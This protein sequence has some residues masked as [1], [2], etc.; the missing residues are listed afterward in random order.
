[1]APPIVYASQAL[2]RQFTGTKAVAANVIVSATAT[3]RHNNMNGGSGALGTI[4]PPG[5]STGACPAHHNRGHLIGNAIGGPGGDAQNLVTLVSGTN[6]P[7][8]YEYED[9]LKRFVLLQTSHAREPF[10]YKVECDYAANAY[11]L[12]PGFPVPGAT[13]NPFCLFPA[14]ARL[15]LSV[16]DAA[17]TAVTIAELLAAAGI[18]WSV[19]KLQGFY[20]T[21]MIGE[22]LIIPNGVFKNYTGAVHVQ[23]QCWAVTHDPLLLLTDATNYSGALGY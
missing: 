11:S 17:N 1:V 12:T 7:I 23:N 9:Y 20:T 16:T 2:T 10:S 8:M 6:H 13:G 3:L 5:W 21:S 22:R 4:N 15:A 14:P 19:P 18:V